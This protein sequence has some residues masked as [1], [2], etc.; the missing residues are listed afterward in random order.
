MDDESVVKLDF[1]GGIGCYDEKITAIRGFCGFNYSVDFPSARFFIAHFPRY[2]NESFNLDPALHH[3]ITFTFPL[4][5]KYSVY[6]GALA[7]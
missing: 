3:K 4:I 1:L 2:L 5:V 6:R 7:I